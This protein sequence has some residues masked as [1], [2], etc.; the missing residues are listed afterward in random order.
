MTDD[1]VDRIDALVDWQL[2][3]GEPPVEGETIVLPSPRHY[4]TE[5]CADLQPE[6]LGDV[7]GV[8]E[9]IIAGAVRAVFFAV[10]LPLPEVLFEE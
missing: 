1:I 10:G 7:V 6:A 9:G 2:A 5:H 8:A 4:L 3:K